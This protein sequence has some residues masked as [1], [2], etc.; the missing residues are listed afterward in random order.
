MRLGALLTLGIAIAVG[1]ASAQT[2]QNGLP[3]YVEGYAKWPK[4][5]AKPIAGGSP[6][7]R[8]TKNVYASKRKQGARYPVGTIVV[9]AAMPPGQALALARRD[10]ATD[11]GPGERR[12][13]LGG[14]HSTSA[15][16]RFSKVAFPESG[17]AACHMQ[18]SSNDYVFTR[19]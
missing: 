14:V 13:A 3:G 4:V 5:N 12:L 8:G 7:H 2:R 18:A 1:T 10:D 17:C 6:A 15:S 16:Q 19:R 11:Q 9:K